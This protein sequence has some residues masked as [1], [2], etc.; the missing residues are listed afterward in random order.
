[1]SGG[2]DSAV[3]CDLFYKAKFKFAVAHCNFGL[4]GKE[5]DE[6][7]QFVKKLATKYKVAFHSERFNTT[8]FAKKNKLSIQMAARQLRYDWFEKIRTEN[9][10]NYIATA[11][12]QDD[13]IETFFINLIRGTGIAGLHGISEKNNFIIR[14]LLFE[15]R[16]DI[17]IYCKKEKLKFREDSS[18]SSTKYIRNKIRHQIIP[19]LKEINP[20]LNDTI[21]KDIEKL[22]DV[23]MIYRQAIQEKCLTLTL[24]DGEGNSGAKIISI[25]EI[26][27]LIPQKTWLYELLKPFN[28]NIETIDEI[29]FSLNKKSSGKQFISSTHRIVRDREHLIINKIADCELAISDFQIKKNQTE[30]SKEQLHLKFS[31]RNQKSKIRNQKNIAQ[32]D[33]AQLQ[34]PLTVRKWEEGDFFQPLGMKGRKKVSDF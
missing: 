28:F 18:N 3:M 16:T 19:V 10:Y 8:A 2:I 31:I 7:E 9:H 32:L 21:K 33:F 20:N 5:S 25:S 34:F 23:E 4:R 29:I 6:D 17:E 26:K 15:T 14:P 12:H 27:K 30:I 11:H 1:M 24:S 13:E 22:K